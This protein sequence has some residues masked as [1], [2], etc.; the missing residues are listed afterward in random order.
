MVRRSRRSPE[1][2]RERNG[3]SRRLCAQELKVQ[4]MC[5]TFRT[6]LR[7]AS[8]RRRRC[9]KAE[10]DPVVLA[11]H[12]VDILEKAE[13]KPDRDINKSGTAKVN[14]LSSLE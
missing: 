6:P 13:R 9:R 12:R 3:G 8:V 5:L 14:S 10:N 4:K 2:I 7:F 11:E 1:L